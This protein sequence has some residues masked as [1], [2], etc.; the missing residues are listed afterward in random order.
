VSSI[1]SVSSTINTFISPHSHGQVAAARPLPSGF[2]AAAPP[3]AV[4]CL[5]RSP[6][7]PVHCRQSPSFPV[8]DDGG[9]LVLQ[10]P[11]GFSHARIGAT[12][13]CLSRIATPAERSVTAFTLAAWERKP[14]PMPGIQPGVCPSSP[15]S[16]TPDR[17][18]C[19][20]RIQVFVR[21]L[22]TDGGSCVADGPDAVKL[23]GYRA[24][25]SGATPEGLGEIGDRL[26][27]GTIRRSADAATQPGLQRLPVNGGQQ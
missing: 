14:G 17:S 21:S 3:H 2:A 10:T 9:A 7:C 6:H 15:R 23:W 13:T 19:P 24:D 5:S 8:L 20:D 1:D 16:S 27:M 11:D 25:M 4:F 18:H 26:W 22:P 12:R